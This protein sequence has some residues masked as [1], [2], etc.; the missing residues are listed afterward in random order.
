MNNITNGI[1]AVFMT[2]IILFAM[3]KI[4][5]I[6]IDKGP[7]VVCSKI[8]NNLIDLIFSNQYEEAFAFWMVNKEEVKSFAEMCDYNKNIDTEE[9]FR[10]FIYYLTN[11]DDFTDMLSLVPRK[12]ILLEVLSKDDWIVYLKS[13]LAKKQ[14]GDKLKIKE[15]E[16]KTF[17][18]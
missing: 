14:L 6:N 1:I 15:V 13:S 3:Y 2:V 8:F 7:K 9:D 5:S 17:K 4:I 16:E 11:K 18:V 10:E 12:I